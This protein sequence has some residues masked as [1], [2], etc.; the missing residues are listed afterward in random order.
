MVRPSRPAQMGQLKAAWIN[1]SLRSAKGKTAMRMAVLNG[2]ASHP[3]TCCTFISLYPSPT[4]KPE[5]PYVE[6][7]RIQARVVDPYTDPDIIVNT[8]LQAL[9]DGSPRDQMESEYFCFI[10][11]MLNPTS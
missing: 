7:G 5:T 6:W 8:Y 2:K 9:A 3:A 1:Q 10:Y 4:T 11:S